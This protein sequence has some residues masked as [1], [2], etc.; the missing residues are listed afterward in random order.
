MFLSVVV[1]TAAV[2]DGV[3]AGFGSWYCVDVFCILRF[4]RV[5][6]CCRLFL[7]EHLTV[8]GLGFGLRSMFGFPMVLYVVSSFYVFCFCCVFGFLLFVCCLWFCACCFFY[9]FL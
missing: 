8:F 6:S 2:V 5:F 1:D 3:A 4:F 7:V 9:R